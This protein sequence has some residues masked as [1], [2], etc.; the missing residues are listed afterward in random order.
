[1]HADP[2][3]NINQTESAEDRAKRIE[4][5][6]R[7]LEKT[8]IDHVAE[9]LLAVPVAILGLG[10]EAA[11]ALAIAA[12]HALAE[13]AIEHAPDAQHYPSSEPVDAGVPGDMSGSEA[14]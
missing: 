10:E 8:L 7:P 4:A 11:K 1:V 9:D 6:D 14:Q 3:G 5:H 13:T 12:G 2:S